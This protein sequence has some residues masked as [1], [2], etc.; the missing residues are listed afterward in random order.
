MKNK[1][2]E[3]GNNKKWQQDINYGER[4]CIASTIYRKDEDRG[5][6]F[7]KTESWMQNARQTT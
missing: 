7:I 6:P 4:S 2:D 3:D 5:R 1:K